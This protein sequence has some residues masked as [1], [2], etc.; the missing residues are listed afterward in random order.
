MAASRLRWFRFGG[1]RTGAAGVVAPAPPVLAARWA[2]G[3]GAPSVAGFR[4]A[5][6]AQGWGGA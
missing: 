1:P 4:S 6:V 2:A 3:A 5:E